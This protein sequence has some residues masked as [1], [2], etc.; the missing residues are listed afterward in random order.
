MHCFGLYTCT[1]LDMYIAYRVL[2]C[3]T[4]RVAA[5]IPV[6]GGCPSLVSQGQGDTRRSCLFSFLLCWLF[7]LLAGTSPGRHGNDAVDSQ[8]TEITHNSR[9]SLSLLDILSPRLG[10]HRTP[11]THTERR[12]RKKKQHFSSSSS[13]QTHTR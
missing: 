11:R 6:V 8:T 5:P 13:R 12:S 1:L 3:W 2:R 7:G 9:P 4:A 10:D